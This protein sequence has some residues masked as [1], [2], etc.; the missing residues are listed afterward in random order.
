[1]AIRALL[2]WVIYSGVGVLMLKAALD[3]RRAVAR[4]RAAVGGDFDKTQRCFVTELELDRRRLPPEAER[5]LRLSRVSLSFGLGMVGL[6][7]T[8]QTITLGD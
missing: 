3:R 5:L 4:W 7:L 2:L 8:V 1:M 6:A